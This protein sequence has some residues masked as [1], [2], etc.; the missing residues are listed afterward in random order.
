MLWD[1]IHF[2]ISLGEVIVAVALVLIAGLIVAKIAFWTLSRCLGKLAGTPARSDS[3]EGEI[4]D[5][6][7]IPRP[8]D[9]TSIPPEDRR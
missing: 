2:F 8:P 6:I 1:A 4:Y 5:Y 9:D 3:D 7:A